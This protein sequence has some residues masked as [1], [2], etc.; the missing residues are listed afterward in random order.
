MNV[1]NFTNIKAFFLDNKTVKQTIFKN[2]FWLTIGTVISRILKLILLIYV[3]RILGVTEYGKF[4]FALSF[5]SLFIVFANL[6]LPAIITREFARSKDK[7]KEFYSVLSLKIIL[8]IGALILILFSSFFITSDLEIRKLIW[9]LAV[10][11]LIDSFYSIIYGFFCAR[12]RMEYEALG[13]ILNGL[14]VTCIGLFVIFNFPSIENLSFAYLFASII[15]LFFVLILFHL[16]FLS[17]K[18]T[19]HKKVW[20]KFLSQSWPLALASLF[21]ALYVNI[22][23]TMMGFLNQITETGWY[24][25]AYRIIYIT[26]LPMG[27]ISGSFFPVF[28]KLAIPTKDM[29]SSEFKKSREK[30]Q[31]VWDY[32]L[33]LMIF[34]AIPVVIGGV[35]FAPKIIDFIYGQSFS[36]SI[37]VFQI[38]ILMTG[39]TFF[40]RPFSD[41]L[42]ASNQQ[43]KIFFVAFIGAIIN[44]ILNL[45]FIPMYS[46]YGAAGAT[47]ITHILIFI[48]FFKFTAEYTLIKPFNW[49]FLF[50]LIGAFFCSLPMY[51]V[52]SQPLIY[53]FNIF[54]SIFIGAIIY[55]FS[56][57][58]LKLIVK[59]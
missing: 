50:W 10:F 38:L 19:W 23:S 14:I 53:N 49:K 33:K 56:F 27:L 31:K 22:D 3:A 59:L 37:L 35:V 41:V 36:P 5:V 57:I 58:S 21:G 34:L 1:R 6:G 40:Y 30:L 4:T 28:S 9:I 7:L 11:V 13:E 26:L 20:Q 54:L 25:A 18:L 29:A 42:V 46:L 17:L 44:I 8:S 52:I 16:K 45:I 15:V 48:L 43:K 24:N 32:N 55:F 51:V 39:I 47:V 2:T 12:Q